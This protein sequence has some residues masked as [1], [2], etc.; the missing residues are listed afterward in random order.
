MGAEYS[1]VHVEQGFRD[2]ILNDQALLLGL[3][4]GRRHQFRCLR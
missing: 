3:L 4:V 2:A 1:A